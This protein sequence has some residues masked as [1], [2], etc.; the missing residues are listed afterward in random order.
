MKKSIKFILLGSILAVVAAAALLLFVFKDSIFNVPTKESYTF[1]NPDPA[2]AETDAGMKIDGVFDEAVYSQNTWTYLHNANGGNTVDLA[3]TSYF[4]EKGIYFAYEVRESTPIYVNMDRASWMNS[5]IEMYLVPSSVEKMPSENIFEI[6]LLPTG[7]LLFK[8]PNAAGGWSDVSTTHDKMAYLGAKPFGGEVNTDECT[9]YDLELFI[10]YDYLDVLGV[11]SQLVKDGYVNVNPCHITSYNEDGTDGSVDRF[12]YSFGKQLGGDGWNDVNRYFKFNAGGAMGT[13]PV[14]MEQGE[15]CT[16]SGKPNAIPGLNTTVTITPDAGYALTSILCNGEEL[17]PYVN[18][19]EDGSAVVTLPTPNEGFSFEAAAEPISSGKKTLTGIVELKNIFGDTLEGVSASYEDASGQHKLEISSDG[20][21]LLSDIPQG[22]YIIRVKK[23]GYIKTERTLCVNRDL[24]VVVEMPYDL[25]QTENGNCWNY[26]SANDGI[27]T[28]INGTGSIL[29]KDS[30]DDFYAE[31]NFAYSEELSKEFKGDDY[32][33]QRIGLR[34][35]FD[36]GKYWHIDLLRQNDGKY[37]LQFGKIL[38]DDSLFNWDLVT[39]LTASQIACYQSEEGIKLGVLRIGRTAYIYLDNALVGKT[40]LGAEQASCKAQIGFESFVSN[41][42][43]MTVPFAL[44]VTAPAKVQLTDAGSVGATVSLSGEHQIGETVTIRIHKNTSQADAKLL[45]VQVN[46]KELAQDAVSAV[47]GYQVTIPNNLEKVLC[48]KVIYSEPEKKTVELDVVDT[49]ADG[50]SVRLKQDGSVKATA[51]VQNGKAVFTDIDQGTYEVQVRIFGI[52]TDLDRITVLEEDLLQ[53]D[54]KTLFETVDQTNYS[55][56]VTFSGTNS[57]YYSIATDISGDAW[58]AMKLQMDKAKLEAAAANKGNI[59][60][61]YRMFFGGYGGNY[62]WENEYEITLKYTPEGN[63]VFEQMNTWQSFEIP[64]Q[65]VEALT[66]EG[67]HMALHREQRTG[68]VTLHYGATE[69]ELLSGQYACKWENEKHKENIRRF[70]VGFWSENGSNYKA[71]VSNLR[72]GTSLSQLFGIKETT[73]SLQLTGHKDGTYSVLPE[74]TQVLVSNA[75]GEHRLTAD[76]SGK[77]HCQVLPGRYTVSVDGY[78]GASIEVPQSGIEGQLAL[79]YDL[80]HIPTGWDAEK[81]DLSKVND[82]TPGISMSGGTMNVLTNDRFSDVSAS[83]WV[84]ESN[85]THSAH[86]QGIWIRFE[87][88][89]YMILYQ[90]DAKLAYMQNLWDFETV[91][92]AYA[93]VCESLP[94]DVLNKW[95]S[96]GY[97][98]RLIR[99]ENRLFVMA[100]GTL[101]HTEVLPEMYADDQVQIG[102]FAYDSA[103]E[104]N[105]NFKIQSDFPAYSILCNATQNGVVTADKTS[106][107]LGETV[108]LTVMP[109]NGYLLKSLMV[110]GKESVQNVIDGKLSVTVLGNITVDAVFESAYVNGLITSNIAVENGTAIR[111]LQD[112]TVLAESTFADGKANMGN[113]IGG[114]YDAEL[115]VFGYWAKLKPLNILSNEAVVADVASL[116]ENPEFADFDGNISFEGT[117]IKHSSVA[118]DISGDAWFTMKV[119]VDK[120]QLNAV[121]ANKGNIRLGYRLFFGGESGNYLWENEFEPTLKYTAEGRWVIEQMNSW[122][123]WD[124]YLSDEMVNA[125]TGNGLYLALHRNAQSGVLTL[126]YGATQAELL[127]QSNS[128]TYAQRSAKHKETITRFG[129]GF[130]SENGSDYQATVSNLRYSTSLQDSMETFAVTL[131]TENVP[132]STVIRF[133]QNGKECVSGAVQNGQAVFDAVVAGSYQVEVKIFNAWSPVTS[134]NVSEDMTADIDVLS[135]F[136]NREFANFDGNISFTGTTGKNYSAATDISGDAWFAMKVQIDKAQLDAVAANKGNIRLGFRMFFGGEPGNSQWANE[137]E[138]TLKYTAEG[139]WIVEQMQSWEGW[140]YYLSQDA[141]HALTGDGLYIAMHRNVKTG[142]LTLYYGASKGEMLFNSFTYSQAASKH[143]ENITRFGVA[144]WSEKGSD[145]TVTIS[146]L[147]YGATMED[148]TQQM[149]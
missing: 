103:A 124:Y 11:D 125:L 113:I 2:R 97:E 120:A 130:W 148:A 37:H 89:K 67:L 48:V 49:A 41:S 70:G 143:K 26:S 47:G 5:C 3:I 8:R 43:V 34:I 105:W 95:T 15:N 99:K 88:G 85:S 75:M 56:N 96:N 16:I 53:T 35:K 7:Y 71:S 65:M 38:G 79:E 50:I 114:R 104:A 115:L 106:A 46:G 116:F 82:S 22:Y 32:Q 20:S 31:A 140:N 93:V 144:F 83:L 29:T 141:I 91:Q 142:V 54:I 17:L 146:D 135:V 1:I 121:A 19:Q 14:E 61:G 27:L 108:T 58:F 134:V 64:A 109:E 9:G 117:A 52:W 128:F 87:D 42:K 84:K 102:F 23:D 123:G 45:S 44:D 60:L 13:V 112:G 33:Q 74:N 131:N 40:D 21:F 66:G 73:I 51:I 10:P 94:N 98:L 36:N 111:L 92:N 101:Y 133:T 59:R 72:Y 80:F 132:D 86:T 69:A 149:Q 76:G 145:Y 77:I 107:R 139:R 55:G 39:E 100:D 122:E 28:K 63:W 138:L 68:V 110:N 126:Y 137:Y 127:A 24:N 119:Q 6:D 90:E 81:H 12:W 4:G 129:A 18:Y 78:T 57:R 30:L 147:C 25:M 62:E 118:A 136:E